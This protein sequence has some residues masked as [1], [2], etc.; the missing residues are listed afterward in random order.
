MIPHNLFRGFLPEYVDNWRGSMSTQRSSL[1][2]VRIFEFLSSL[3]ISSVEFY[4]I[5]GLLYLPQDF[6]QDF[7]IWL[8][9]LSVASSIFLSR[10]LYLTEDPISGFIYLPQKNSLTDWGSYQWVHLSS[11]AGFF[12]E[13]RILYAGW[14]IFLSRI[15]FY[16]TEDLICG[17]VYIP[18]NLISRILYLTEDPFNVTFSKKVTD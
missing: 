18:Q 17:F 15:F 13:L 7:F 11:S 1:H 6:W 3:M 10:I 4:P 5:S 9:I 12:I 14:S 2:L 8:R 16:L